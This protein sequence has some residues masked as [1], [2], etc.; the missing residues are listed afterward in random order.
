M[1]NL[2]ISVFVFLFCIFVFFFFHVY[3]LI[4][5]SQWL[6][7]IDKIFVMIKYSLQIYFVIPNS[8]VFLG[9]KYFK[10]SFVHSFLRAF[11]LLAGSRLITFILV[12]FWRIENLRH[13]L[14]VF[15]HCAYTKNQLYS[16]WTRLVDTRSINVASKK[17]AI[18]WKSRIF[19]PRVFEE[20]VRLCPN[21]PFGLWKSLTEL[22]E[23]FCWLKAD[24][25][26]VANS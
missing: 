16:Y 26:L 12:P 8:N 20:L 15:L 24:S 13:P 3:I 14:F 18:P 21:L 17:L 7:K 1:I 19:H 25:K 22:E 23:K 4:V 9:K 6:K 5:L 11:V 2:F 10:V